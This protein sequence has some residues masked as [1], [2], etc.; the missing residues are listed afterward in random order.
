ML[1]KKKKKKKNVNRKGSSGRF[2]PG[3]TDVDVSKD[4]SARVE[5]SDKRKTP[6]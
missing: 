3:V 4:T 1:K 6:D 2:L 5:P